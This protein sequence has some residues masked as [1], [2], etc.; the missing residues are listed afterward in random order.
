MGLDTASAADR[1]SP[2]GPGS[3]VK[4][5]YTTSS[6]AFQ[7]LRVADSREKNPPIYMSV[8]VTANCHIVFGDA[9]VAPATAGDALFEPTDG[10]QDFILRA[11]HTGFR[12]IGDTAGSVYIFFSGP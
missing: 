9:N 12:V 7:Q 5:T 10:W 2:G 3:T 4:F 8:K 6:S 11:G 1:Y